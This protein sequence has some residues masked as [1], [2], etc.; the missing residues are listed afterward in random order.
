VDY[1]AQLQATLHRL[2]Y[3]RLVE[4]QANGLA[5][6]LDLDEYK[7]LTSTPGCT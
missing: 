7:K 3:T 1:H 4:E 5:T 6:N 2:I